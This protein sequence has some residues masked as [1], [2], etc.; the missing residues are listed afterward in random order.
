MSDGDV[1]DDGDDSKYDDDNDDDSF[2]CYSN[3]GTVFFRI[4]R[5]SSASTVASPLILS[6]SYCAQHI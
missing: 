6:P 5:T 4:R 2:D 1:G 3:R